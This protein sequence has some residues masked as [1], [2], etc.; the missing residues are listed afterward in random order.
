MKKIFIMF[1]LSVCVVFFSLFYVDSIFLADSS[2][3]LESKE[4]I[5]SEDIE[6]VIG[7]IP[8]NYSNFNFS[9]DFNRAV[10]IANNLIYL[11]DIASENINIIETPVFA[12]SCSFLNDNYIIY[13]SK[14]NTRV[15]IYIY[16]ILES[17]SHLLGSLSYKNFI[18]LDNP[19]LIDDELFFDIRYSYNNEILSRSYIYKNN[20]FSRKSSNEYYIT[21][22][23]YLDNDYVYTNNDKNTYINNLLFTYKNNSSYEYIGVDSNNLIYLY[24]TKNENKIVSIS[25]SDTID[26][27]DEYTMDN[28]EYSR[29]FC[30]DKIYLIGSNFILDLNGGNKI[31]LEKEGNILY[32]KNNTI[33]YERYGVLYKQYF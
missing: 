23:A 21:K 27:V 31:N 1:L 24:D 7:Y 9:K 5:S 16:D 32:I 6:K 8:S 33:L 25:L 20:E 11:L 30:S 13:S 15:S 26:I 28:I 22:S 18:S 12:N 17:K 14:D 3:K 10:F 4:E 2:V 19:I 29:F